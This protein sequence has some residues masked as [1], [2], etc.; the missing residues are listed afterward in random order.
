MGIKRAFNAGKIYSAY[1]ADIE[2]RANDLEN[3]DG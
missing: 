1:K 3:L 2:R